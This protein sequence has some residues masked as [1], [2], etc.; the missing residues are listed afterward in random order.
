M[1]ALRLICQFLGALVLLGVALLVLGAVLACFGEWGRKRTADRART[2]LSICAS[3]GEPQQGGFC[4]NCAP[5]ARPEPYPTIRAEDLRSLTD[6]EID[7]HLNAPQNEWPGQIT[8]SLASPD[9]LER[10]LGPTVEEP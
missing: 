3:C 2:V 7:L 9:T 8:P 10:L 6:G 4:Q 1:N 5:I